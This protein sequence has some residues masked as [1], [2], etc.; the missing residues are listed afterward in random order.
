MPM[1]SS[2][3][4][5]FLNIHFAASMVSEDIRGLCR[6]VAT[7]TDQA[8]SPCGSSKNTVFSD[9]IRMYLSGLHNENENAFRTSIGSSL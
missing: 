4:D 8:L 5:T 9:G 7:C 6:V 2:Q 3:F 1:I